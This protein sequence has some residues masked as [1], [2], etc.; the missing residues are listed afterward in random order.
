MQHAQL[1]KL[2]ISQRGSCLGDVL[3][4]YPHAVQHVVR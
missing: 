4:P 1:L 3:G 2:L